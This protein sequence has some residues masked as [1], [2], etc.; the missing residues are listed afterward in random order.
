MLK[1]SHTDKSPQASRAQDVRNLNATVALD[2]RYLNGEP[3]G[4]GRYT[5]N[6][7]ECL[8][9]IDSRLR[10]RLITSGARPEPFDHDRVD[11][12]VFRAPANSLRTRYLLPHS[13]DFS[14]VD[15]FHSPFNI[16]PADLPCPSVFTLHD[17]MW[18][19]KPSYCARSWWRKM[20]TGTFY[21]KAITA[22]VESAD[23]V[24]TISDHSRKEIE[25]Y[26]PSMRGRVHVAY[27]AVDEFFRPVA[28]GQGWPLIS[29]YVPPRSKF[30]LIVGQGTPYKNHL[31]AV[32]GFVEAFEND[33]H[34][35]LVMV[36]RLTRQSEPR[37]RYLLE[38]SPIS[39]R[40]IQLD[41][42]TGRQLRALYSLASAFVFPSF[43]EGFG[44]PAL[45]AMA[46]GTP[47]VTSD[48]GAPAEVAGQAA[49]K[50]DPNS[51]VAIGD[52]LR[53]AVI[54]PELNHKYGNLGR[55]RANRFDWMQSAVQTHAVYDKILKSE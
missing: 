21:Q 4:I 22:S 29:K 55:K 34:V 26:F 43:Y 28:P 36:R 44:L 30:V 14:G 46:C 45:E 2:A 24:L 19:I 48:R 6:L 3:S 12:E 39:S 7:I 38:E 27:N 20:I 13:V 11:C 54:D 23:R 32:E 18:L 52:A 35:Y 10:L 50:V 51:P 37:L 1:T 8:L 5:R 31:G 40:I 9:Q 53:D 15:L 41:G 17:I 25:D 16:L 42:V 49:L 33:P 47:V